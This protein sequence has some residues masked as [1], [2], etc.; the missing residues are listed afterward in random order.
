MLMT[1]TGG[2]KYAVKAELRKFVSDFRA[3]HGDLAIER[4][5]AEEVEFNDLS[6]A[7]TSLSLFSR[8]KLS[9]IFNPSKNKEFV[10]AAEQLLSEAHES[11][12]IILVEDKL[13]KRLAF[14]K[15][16]KKRTDFKDFNELDSNGLSKWLS[17]EAKARGGSLSTQDA[18]YLVD[19]VGSDQML[20]SNELDK[21]VIHDPKVNRE[22][23]DLL[24]ESSP[25]STIFQLIESAFGPNTK[26]TLL[27][28]D[29]QRQQNVEPQQVI[30]MLTWQLHI[31][32]TL[33]TAKD[34]S[35]D[36]IAKDAGLNPFVVRKSQSAVISIS[37]DK[38][39]TMIN[40]LLNL[41]RALKSKP[42]DADMAIRHYLLSLST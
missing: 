13:D 15:L 42:I 32:A 31:L 3:I 12:D 30:A 27:L 1:L 24:T 34:K 28:Y 22:S 40:D 2:N 38:L 35:A 8:D 29:E 4:I 16:L 26:R 17:D 20:L 33:K 41:D 9:I 5:D 25:Q 7:F 18:R 14:Y 6:Q 21:L 10:E 37:L 19:R 23:I 36:Q 39:K 11:S